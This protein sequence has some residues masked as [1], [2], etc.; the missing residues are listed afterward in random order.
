M[1]L[2]IALKLSLGAI[3][4]VL[5]MTWVTGYLYYATAHDVLVQHEIIDLQDE[6]SL[7][8]RELQASL[9]QLRADALTVAAKLGGPSEPPVH[10]DANPGD[11]QLNELK[12]RFRRHREI[13]D[14]RLLYTRQGQ[15]RERWRLAQPKP[16]MPLEAMPT[17]PKDWSDDQEYQAAKTTP[18]GEVYWG[19]VQ[20]SAHDTRGTPRQRL[21]I[22]VPVRSQTQ[23][24]TSE[25]LRVEIDFNQLVARFHQMPRHLVYLIDEQDRLLVTPF[26]LAQDG[27]P[28]RLSEDAFLQPVVTE[29]ERLIAVMDPVRGL[30]T[31]P[32]PAE[33]QPLVS[34]K[35]AFWLVSSQTL[36]PPEVFD[37][38]ALDRQMRRLHVE[39]PSV[40]F[41]R[42]DPRAS[43]INI[44]CR[45]RHRLEQVMQRIRPKL[46]L[47]E[48]M[49]RYDEVLQWNEPVYCQRFSFQYVTFTVPAGTNAEPNNRA[50]RYRL[51]MGIA[52]EEIS[53]DIAS[54]HQGILW[55]TI[56]LACGAAV[57]A[58]FFSSILTRP[59]KRMIHAADRLARGETKDLPLPIHH[60]D[61][62][63]NLARAFERMM[64]QVQE[65]NAA[66][67]ASEAHVR[68]L[69]DS[70][71]DAIFTLDADGRLVSF[72]R[73]A[74]RL[75][76]YEEAEARGKSYR[77]FIAQPEEI[78][79]SR[80]GIE[81][82]ESFEQTLTASRL[83]REAGVRRELWA[84]RKD[85]TVFPA[86]VSLN[87]VPL[88]GSAHRLYAVILRDI[89]ARK[90]QEEQI[91]LLNMDLERRV[92]ER[93][94]EL[95]QAN[96]TLEQARDL[97][98][99]S[100]RT[101]DAFL[102]TMSHELRTP[103]NAII[104]YC[105]FLQ[106]ELQTNPLEETL[107]DLQK[108]ES[109][110]RHLLTLINDILDLAKIE[111]GKMQLE[112]RE[113]PV[114]PLLTELRDL[115]APL[116]RARDNRFQVYVDPHVGTMY[117]DRTRVRQVLLNL[118]SN[119]NKFTEAGEI[120]LGVKREAHDEQP[121]L[122]FAVRDTGK[123]MKEA[124]V[125]RL[126]TAFYQADSTSTRKHEGTG[127]GLTISRRICNLMGGDI[128]VKSTFGIGST[129]TV[130][131]PATLRMLPARANP[132]HS[133]DPSFRAVR[134]PRRFP[135][136]LVVDDDAD[137][138]D[139]MT[140]FL[141]REGYRVRTAANGEE[142]VRLARELHPSAITL[143]AMMPGVDGW[144]VL[145]TLKS[146][147]QTAAIPIV[148]ATILDDQT[149]G[150]A[151]GASDYIT[152]PV[153]RDRLLQ[154]LGQHLPEH[155]D[156]ILVVE[157]DSDT[158]ELI[159]RVLEREAWRV[160]E[161]KDGQAALEAV[162]RERPGLILL[163]LM[164][165][166]MDGF[167]FASTLRQRGEHASI[168]IIV[169]TAV[170]LT[171]DEQMRLNGGVQQILQKGSY[172]PELLLQEIRIRVEQFLR[173]QPS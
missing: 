88:S 36:P 134:A 67:A 89:T 94:A 91:R 24:D 21:T 90:E 30:K 97:A 54:A 148:M 62:I 84:R 77:E 9:E 152:K 154:V 92:A 32:L 126:F 81:P 16:E 145:A 44:S 114:A 33:K 144:S 108:I 172:T 128:S 70:A 35:H 72:N 1:R 74:V 55:L 146:D 64:T 142:G 170:D 139:L 59:L 83:R 130:R 133:P 143:D 153:D 18:W 31:A 168:P 27:T 164:M 116:M 137:V 52:R 63:G 17:Q 8:A 138:R 34:G 14:V 65:R 29:A 56:A 78:Q 93:T 162:D 20:V 13:V 98:L 121:W 118:L 95:V 135:L 155:T 96:H 41:G 50:R 107:G 6:T 103:L 68:T 147:P 140:R 38:M 105:E 119:A 26:G 3:A 113:F 51:V 53:D 104:G 47:T 163:D 167:T 71:A 45:D 151:L 131:L 75:F 122:V 149:R 136:I 115:L 2:G 43:R 132:E 22:L 109:A 23:P 49:A 106:E 87:E 159:R 123:G 82:V 66:L 40:R 37:R 173:Q 39:F 80:L 127:L 129:F 25:T 58:L 120:E 85:G 28:R 10:H 4:L 161:A 12:S 69:L 102:A 171:P 158:R 156:P 112:P 15:V 5:T 11:R 48:Q 46:K 124:E 76:G 169:V 166:T 160:I 79:D 61:E 42:V 125:Q 101:K 141:L 73:A 111:A 7:R 110:G 99:E 117:A 60:K 57:G 157:D 19:E 100:A 86:E 165:P 150:F